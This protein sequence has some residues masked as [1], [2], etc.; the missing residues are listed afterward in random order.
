MRWVGEKKLPEPV[1]HLP[2]SWDASDVKA[3]HKRMREEAK[4]ERRKRQRNSRKHPRQKAGS[5]GNSL[6]P[7]TT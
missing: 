1:G 4:Q 3:A 2:M 7:V 5:S 6:K